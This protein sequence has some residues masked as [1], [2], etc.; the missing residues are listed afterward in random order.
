[1]N[2]IAHLSCRGGGMILPART[3]RER[4]LLVAMGEP[5]IAEKRYE[6]SSS[7]SLGG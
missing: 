5:Q 3:P 6:R 7:S 2:D 1:M 4:E